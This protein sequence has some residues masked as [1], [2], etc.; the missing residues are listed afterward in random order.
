MEDVSNSSKRRKAD[1]SLEQ[2]GKSTMMDITDTSSTQNQNMKNIIYTLVAR[3]SILTFISHLLDDSR[4][5]SSKTNGNK[6]SKS[7]NSTEEST[8][9]VGIGSII[10]GVVQN[11]TSFG[12]FLDLRLP[13]EAL[14]PSSLKRKIG[15]DDNN[16]KLSKSNNAY[17]PTGLLHVSK[18]RSPIASYSLGQKVRIKIE[19]IDSD[20]KRIALGLA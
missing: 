1:L 11:I 17:S 6:G 3:S 4:N 19:S 2:S 20:R 15:D 14:F 10:A 5:D 7:D 16:N 18:L 13:F 9:K 12:I 8:T